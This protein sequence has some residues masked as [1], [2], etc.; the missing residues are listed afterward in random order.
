MPKSSAPSR[1]SA[2]R[3][4]EQQSEHPSEQLAMPATEGALAIRLIDMAQAAGTA[5]LV[6]V[7]G[8]E[9]R[10]ERLAT[11]IWRLAPEMETIVFPAWDSLPYDRTSPSRRAMGRRFAA[12]AALAQP[13]TRPRLV[14][15][16]PDGLLQRLPPRGSC[17]AATLGVAV[18]GAI[19]LDELTP[20]LQRIGYFADERVDEPGEF[21]LRGQVLDIF[22]AGFFLP[23]RVTHEDGRVVSIASYEAA[24]QRTTDSF[25]ELVLR[26]TSEA[27]L[28]EPAE[29]E[30]A[31]RPA[32]IEHRLHELYPS[33]DTLFDYV[34]GATF[35]FGPRA[36]A[37]QDAFLEQVAD[38]YQTRVRLNQAGGRPPASDRL[39]LDAAE[40]DTRL[41]AHPV[42]RFEA[43]E[44]EAETVPVF[45]LAAKPDAALSAFLEA[46]R[47]NRVVLAVADEGD[48]KQLGRRLAKLT[49]T[50]PAPAG[51]WAE[52]ERAKPGT[53]LAMPLGIDRGFRL[54]DKQTTFIAAGD[55]LGSR[56][57]GASVANGLLVGEEES[58]RVGD[59]VIHLDHGVGMLHGIEAVETGTG[60]S[61]DT[62]RLGY[63]GDAILMAPIDQID[64][65]WR[66]GTAAHGVTLDR[67]DG[68][69][70]PK[71]RAKVEAE[72][73][74]A[75]V[76]LARLAGA[77]RSIEAPKLKPPSRA[78]ERFVARFPYSE[79]QDQHEAVEAIL[80]DLASGTLMDRLVCGDVGFGKTEVALR[81]AAAAA[82][83]GKQVA[84]VAPTTVLVRQHL[85][86]FKARFADLG[87]EVA[88]LS[89]LVKPAEAK[90]V[91]A[92][93]ADGSIRVVIGTHALAGK[94]I[95]FA[96][97][98]LLIIDEEQHFGAALKE[99]LRAMG[100]SVH[101]LTLTAT[102]IP[103][104]MQAALV[105]LQAVSVLATPPAERR[106]V[107]TIVA[108]F[109]DA[110][111]RDALVREGKRGGQSFVVCP[112]ID[113]IAPMEA[114]LKKLVPELAVFV[115]HG[116]MPADAIDDTMV[117]FAHGEGDVLLATNIIES[118][119]DVPNANTI[120]VWRA[121]RF[122]LAQLH[123]LRGRVGRG[124][125]RGAAY[126]MLDP[127]GAVP[128]A[129]R[130]RLGTLES[131]DRLGAGF[132]ISAEDLEQRGAGDLLGDSQAGHV[133]LIGSG[134]YRR[135]LERAL[136]V[137]RGETPPPDWSPE[138]HIG[139]SGR[140]P[141]EYIPEPEIR[142]N[143]YARIARGAGGDA[144]ARDALLAEIEDRF[145][146][147]PAGIASLIA[148]ARLK[149]ACRS[150]GILRVDA[151]PQAIALTFTEH[152]LGE[153][154]LR[155]RK[156][157]GTSEASGNLAWRGERLV[158]ARQTEDDERLAVLDELLAEIGGP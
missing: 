65:M 67:L 22:P 120:L 12:L 2:A 116:K 148:L 24:S 64:R 95:S 123:Q 79:T 45:A 27:I 48:L 39:Y 136:V 19:D 130:K 25:D 145:G 37:R 138:L 139:V 104:T 75:A 68:E 122:G 149:D 155:R 23:V 40:F 87:I 140:I 90:A 105:G 128:E 132:A 94:G 57:H 124:R 21:A 50:D 82:L 110:M 11:L 154:A 109:D 99:Q 18:G 143:L 20:A 152:A 6:Y 35:A 49:G 81:A 144:A 74:R 118:G 32:G 113:D 47:A 33:L 142:I 42:V 29:G 97:L 69:A 112:Q 44:S 30:E 137:A 4:P 56:A 135:L 141:P 8:S 41:G 77:R 85:G 70:W 119:L 63:G 89:R 5:G 100:E 66:Y 106:P 101:V 7:S 54:P 157:K 80:A 51:D 93:L 76:E 61:T 151:G 102:P 83:A 126:L 73:N 98:G 58:F 158:L 3:S 34:A 92:G 127:D 84:V 15:T 111:V 38:A 150:L 107:R 86:S 129:T 108:D 13:A 36:G 121:D 133:K 43:P 16:V 125:L 62:L 53:L 52:I 115:A 153:A 59:A 96:D 17:E 46:E 28:P 117:R 114:R 1:K 55:L 72:I 131:L 71:R 88:H 146:P 134:L 9:S 147:A 60:E 78:Y 103:R 31:A 26:P 156:G 10:D 14:L 91:K